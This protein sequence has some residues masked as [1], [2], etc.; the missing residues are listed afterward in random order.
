MKAARV[1]QPG[2]GKGI[3]R[4]VV[5]SE[6]KSGCFYGFYGGFR[7]EWGWVGRRMTEGWLL[8]G[9]QKGLESP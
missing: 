1:V 6:R 4:L 7:A 5:E 2:V 8:A 3:V 9:R